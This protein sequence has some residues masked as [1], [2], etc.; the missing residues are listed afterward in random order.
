MFFDRQDKID[1]TK[2]YNI[3]NVTKNS[4]ENEI[5][6]SYKKLA[7]KYHPDR[8]NGDKNSETKFKEISYAYSIIG[9]KEKE[10]FMTNLVKKVLIIQQLDQM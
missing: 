10:I 8:N 2:L 6:K 3:L 9:N 5:K 4:D 1:N 7:M